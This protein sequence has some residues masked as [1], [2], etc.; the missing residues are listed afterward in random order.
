MQGIIIG[1]GILAL[2]G[3][4]YWYTTNTPAPT[5]DDVNPV[6]ETTDTPTTAP[7]VAGDPS[8]MADEDME[9]HTN[10]EATVETRTDGMIDATGEPIAPP[11]VSD[12]LPTAPTTPAAA[13]PTVRKITLDSFN[14]GY[15]Q[16]ELRIK[17]GDTVELT[18][19]N[20][21]GFHDLVIDELGVATKKIRAGE[22]D[23]V[24]FVADRTGTFEYYCS[25][26]SHRA[27]GMLGSL[28]VE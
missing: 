23:T 5:T 4:V 11:V 3:G 12:P 10:A 15:S 28:I 8:A 1:I 7:E 27:Q 25:V 26:G 2:I 6:V 20:S 18:L 22:T 21:D 14:F 16:S 24:T 9:A 19:T 17:Q 13:A